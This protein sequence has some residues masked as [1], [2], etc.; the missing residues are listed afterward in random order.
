[1]DLTW[2]PTGCDLVIIVLR[3]A[4]SDVGVHHAS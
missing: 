2:Q 4:G 1:M 3:F